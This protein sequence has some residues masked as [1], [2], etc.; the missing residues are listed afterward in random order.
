MPKF[1]DYN[2]NQ[3][4]LLPPNLLD[5]LPANHICFVINDIVDKLD[6]RLIESSYSEEGCPAYNPRM[7]VK[8]IFFSYARGIRSSRKIEEL[9]AENIAYR[10]LSA[11]Q[12]PDHGTINLFRKKHLDK[13]EDIFSSVVILCDGLGMVDLSDISIDGAI[14]RANAS[15]HKT[16]DQEDISRLKKKIRKILQEAQ[17]IDEQEDKQFGK[18]KGYN[19]MPEKL[20][21]P[22]TRQAEIKR[23]QDK[24]NKIKKAEIAI[25]QKQ[26][27]AKGAEEK[28]ATN[29]RTHNTTDPDARLM[30]L[31]NGKSYRPAYNGQV[32]AGNQVIVAYDITDDARDINL[33]KPMIDKTKANTGKE[34]KTVK[35]DSGYFNRQDIDA[36]EKEKRINIYIPDPDKAREEYQER[37]NETPKYGRRNFK[38]DQKK[39]E[40]TCPRNKRLPLVRT[41][42]GTK[43][44]ICQ[45]CGNCPVK[46]QCTKGKNRYINF[47]PQL[48][49]SKAKM[50]EK[51]NTEDGKRKYLERMSEVEPVFGNIIY[52]QNAGHFLCRGKPMVKIEFGLIVSDKSKFT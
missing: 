16:Y 24:L 33:L 41:D 52:N 4:M 47:N 19:D 15:R 13:L 29:N 49:E 12:R 20:V 21:N 30:K 6:V 34:V 27:K 25:K 37:N 42:K 36:M 9:A 44:Y 10:Y 39:D 14:F 23:L 45:S 17:K 31:K 3:S 8:L 18:N 48:E 51:L 7:L 38:Y 50:R 5:S 26:A 40:F 28:K 46:S 1:K 2:Q 35:A 11:N 22:E 32:A 43:K